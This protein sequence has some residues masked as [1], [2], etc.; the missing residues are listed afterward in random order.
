MESVVA[1]TAGLNWVI[2]IGIPM[3][4]LVATWKVFTKAGKPG[5]GAI[6]P[7][8]NI[9]LLCNIAS[10]P[11]WWALFYFIPL[12]NIVVDVIV[13]DRIAKRFGKSSRFGLGL[14]F[15]SFVFLPILAFSSARYTSKRKR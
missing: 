10:K 9:V 13:F 12:L 3:I 8:Y 11:G 15:L 14:T 4:T 7:V 5:W 6:I 1:F 2:Y